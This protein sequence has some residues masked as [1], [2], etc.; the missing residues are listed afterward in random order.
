[1]N[2]RLT[3]LMAAIAASLILSTSMALGAAPVTD[4]GGDPEKSTF[5]RKEYSPYLNQAYPQR[6][7]WGETHLHTSYSTDAG[8]FGTR[9]TPDDAYRFAKGE[10]IVSSMAKHAAGSMGPLRP[11]TKSSV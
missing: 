11:S 3:V 9:L 10:E 7:F 5:G 1:M 2:D 4:I 6:V 8:L